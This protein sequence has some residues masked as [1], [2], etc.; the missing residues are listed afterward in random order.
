VLD[1]AAGVLD[2][3]FHRVMADSCPD[4]GKLGGHAT[5]AATLACAGRPE[6]VAARAQRGRE[7]QRRDEAC[8]W[9]GRARHAQWPAL[10]RCVRRHAGT[11]ALLRRDLA[12]QGLRERWG[13]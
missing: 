1:A 2:Q 10:R 5:V 4:C 12:A 11:S 13:I 9:C 6:A 8:P 7:R 3:A